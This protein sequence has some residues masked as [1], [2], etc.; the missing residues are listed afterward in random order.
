MPDRAGEHLSRALNTFR[1]LGAKLD[2]SRAEEELRDLARATPERTQEQ[3]ALTQLLT[4]RLAEA[5]ASRE[6]LLRELAA[7]M[8]QE[9]GA[10]R[11]LIAENGERNEARVVV[12]MGCSSPESAEIASELISLRMTQRAEKYGKKQ[13]A[14]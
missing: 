8:R 12:A 1:E 2:L 10:Q 3:S 13:D 6:L 4:L 11:V 7:V 14:E 9:T 5:V